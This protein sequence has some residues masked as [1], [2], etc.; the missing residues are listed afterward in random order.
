MFQRTEYFKFDFYSTIF[1]IL[2]LVQFSFLCDVLLVIPIFSKRRNCIVTFFCF[3]IWF[4][5]KCCSCL[6]YLH[7]VF[8]RYVNARFLSWAKKVWSWTN[9]T[10][11]LLKFEISYTNTVDIILMKQSIRMKVE[12]KHNFSPWFE[13]NPIAFLYFNP[14]RMLVIYILNG[15]DILTA[16][17]VFSHNDF[18]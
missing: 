3:A 13:M 9:S 17:I 8:C 15:I 5:F 7:Y 11:N 10:Y 4:V 6:I 14:V 16:K 18:F 1:F 12:D 2:L